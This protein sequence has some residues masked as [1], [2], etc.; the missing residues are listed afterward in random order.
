MAEQRLLAVSKRVAHVRRKI[1]AE[2]LQPG[3]IQ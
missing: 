2:S 1:L 3:A